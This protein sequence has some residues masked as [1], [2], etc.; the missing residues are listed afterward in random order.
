MGGV[1]LSDG[2]R[3]P[4]TSRLMQIMNNRSFERKGIPR[5]ATRLRISRGSDHRTVQQ[6]TARLPVCGS[7]AKV[8]HARFVRSEISG[9]TSM[10]RIDYQCRVTYNR[11]IYQSSISHVMTARQ[12]QSQNDSPIRFRTLYAQCNAPRSLNGGKESGKRDTIGLFIL[13]PLCGTSIHDN[14]AMW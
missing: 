14:L 1:L 7:S 8:A 11:R 12:S 4:V 3:L 13:L 10:I 2:I 9:L 5:N 6:T